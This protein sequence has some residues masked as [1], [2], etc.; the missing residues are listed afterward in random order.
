[1][2][3]ATVTPTQFLLGVDGGGSKTTALLADAEGRILG[4][5]SAGTAN[6]FTV[7]IEQACAA[8]EQAVAASFVEAGLNRAPISALCFGLAGVDRPDNRVLFEPWIAEHFP[9]TKAAL[10]NDAELV[11]A[12][13]TPEGW[14]IALI[15]GTG[16]IVFGRNRQDE[17]GRVDGWGYL[18]GDQGSGFS[19][20]LAALQAVMAAHDGRGAPTLLTQMILRHCNLE[21][22]LELVRWIYRE[23]VPTSE[24]AFLTRFVDAA[25]EQGDCIAQ[26][27]LYQAADQL[28]HSVQTLVKKLGFESEIPCA[29]AGGVI[30]NNLQISRSFD[31][32]IA[33]QGITLQPITVVH[34]P[35]QGAIR[36]ALRLLNR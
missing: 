19:I 35:A 29:V 33:R 30:T 32:A 10:V 3:R 11:L 21:S 17:R 36:I 24:I 27:I 20:G 16:M 5:G 34:E 22:P 2:T 4:R 13:G 7:G 23:R 12:A 31:Q 25:A 18:L 28:V 8:I 15:C 6:H 9:N 1:M 14:G 26:T